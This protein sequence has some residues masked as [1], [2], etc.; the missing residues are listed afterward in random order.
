MD[1]KTL[2]AFW[3]NLQIQTQAAKGIWSD[4]IKYP[5]Y[6]TPKGKNDIAERVKR[7]KA[8]LQDIL[9]KTTV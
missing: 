9:K 2:R 4:T 6:S 1:E 8:E 5:Y 3:A 7:I